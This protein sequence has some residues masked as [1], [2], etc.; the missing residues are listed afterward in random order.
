MAAANAAS[1]ALLM[2]FVMLILL[3]V[4]ISKGQ[5]ESGGVEHAY[6]IV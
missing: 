6:R 2:V 5:S 1:S 3:L 4:P